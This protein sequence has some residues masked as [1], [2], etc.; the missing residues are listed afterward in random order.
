MGGLFTGTLQDCLHGTGAARQERVERI[1]TLIVSALISLSWWCH[2]SNPSRIQMARKPRGM[3]WSA[4]HGIQHR[5]SEGL[6]LSRSGSSSV[7]RAA[8]TFWWTKFGV[9]MILLTESFGHV[10]MGVYRPGPSNCLDTPRM[11]QLCEH[12]DGMLTT[13]KFSFTRWGLPWWFSW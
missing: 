2:W 8:Y 3:E 4:S 6:L 7:F 13:W 10:Y 12:Q 1:R 5:K 9:E 11:N